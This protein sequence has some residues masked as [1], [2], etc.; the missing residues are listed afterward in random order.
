MN[1]VSYQY[2][3]ESFLIGLCYIP[4]LLCSYNI[5]FGGISVMHDILLG[6]F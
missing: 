3:V 4:F 5:K 6:T 1:I 2:I